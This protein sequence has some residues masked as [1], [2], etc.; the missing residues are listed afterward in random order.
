MCTDNTHIQ[1]THSASDTCWILLHTLLER[2][3]I[4]LFSLPFCVLFSD[5]CLTVNK[6]A[7]GDVVKNNSSALHSVIHKC[8]VDFI[9]PPQ[10]TKFRV[11][12][13]VFN[14][15]LLLYPT[16]P[17]PP[18]GMEQMQIHQFVFTLLSSYKK[19]KNNYNKWLCCLSSTSQKAWHSSLRTLLNPS[20]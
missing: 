18:F 14:V 7:T 12:C 15:S 8:T 16:S 9:S 5:D 6:A 13:C 20:S 11:C 17:P 10:K 1:Y 19:I 4:W 3:V 2:F